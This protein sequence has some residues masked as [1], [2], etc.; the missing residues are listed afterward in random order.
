MRKEKDTISMG[1]R[2]IQFI[3]ALLM[4]TMICF[5]FVGCGTIKEIQV[6]TIEKVIVRDSLIYVTDSI[7]VEVPKEVIK[8][9]VPQ[10]TVSI[11][12]T[13]VATSEAKIEKGMLHHKL[14]QKG[15]IKTRIDTVFQVQYV[16]RIIE[17][18]VPI[19]VEVI[20]YKRDTIFWFSIIFNILVLVFIGLRIYLKLKI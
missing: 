19:E 3:F 4:I 15:A 17:R 6:Q 13:S 2:V 1:V 10:D 11:L 9:I 14:E 18:D 8:E 16:D 5:S 7:I 12:K 20:K